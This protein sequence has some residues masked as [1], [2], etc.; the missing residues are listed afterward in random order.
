MWVRTMAGNPNDLTDRP[1]DRD[2]EAVGSFDLLSYVLAQLRLSGEQVTEAR[3][4]SPLVISE[5]PDVAYM[6][7]VTEGRLRVQVEKG[8]LVSAETGDLVLLPRSQG[9]ILMGSDG[10]ETPTSTAENADAEIILSRFRFDSHTLEAMVSCLPTHI[11]VRKQDGGQ[12]LAGLAHFLLAEAL[13]TEPGASLMISRL[14]DVMVI[15]AIRHW[16]H[17]CQG[18]GW[19]GGLGDIRIAKVLRA[20]YAAPFYQWSVK[21]LAGIAGMSRSSFSDRFTALVGEPPL[22]YHNHWRLLLA[23][24]LIRNKTIKISEVALKVGYGSDAAF[25]RAFKAYFGHSPNSTGNSSV[26]RH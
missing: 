4:G 7:V 26:D 8:C 16:V 25:S 13:G 9:Q 18:A 12:W 19:L 5:A 2:E 1:R 22:R 21:E 3:V 24:D 15:R 14:I 23:R 17:Q 20:L 6:F 11:H 10:G